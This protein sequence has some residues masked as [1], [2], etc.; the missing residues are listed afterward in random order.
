MKKIIIF[1]LSLLGVSSHASESVKQFPP[2]PKWQP[3]F[4]VSTEIVLDR[5]IYYTENKK[6]LVVFK[7][8]T[9]V[10]VPD[11]LN[12]VEASNYA[13]EVL[14]KIFNFHPDMK[15]LNMDDGNI[16]IQYNHP[17]YNVVINEFANQHFKSIKTN[18]LDAL[19]T[20][21]VIITNLGS[22]KFDNFGMK[23]LYG[24]T[25]MFMDAQKP[26]IINIYRNA[27]NKSL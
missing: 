14:S 16:L 15:P 3:D 27:L 17:A 5:M 1:L 19:A 8:G 12:D 25:F 18:H 21:E 20:S 11:N 23:A 22:N 2:V 26:E 4:T 10:I 6:D 7:N 9:I 24:R 13:L